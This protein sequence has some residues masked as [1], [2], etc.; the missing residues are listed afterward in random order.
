MAKPRIPVWSWRDAIRKAPVSTGVKCLCFSIANYLN[1]AG[2]Y[3]FPSVQTL[4]EE[5]GAAT[6]ALLAR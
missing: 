4:K 3:A 5:Y 6:R 2:G 1:D